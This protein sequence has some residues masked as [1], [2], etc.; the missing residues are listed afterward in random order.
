MKLVASNI[1]YLT[2]NDGDIILNITIPRKHYVSQRVLKNEFDTI[3]VHDLLNIN[4]T[5]NHKSR[6]LNQNNYFWKLVELITEEMTG[7][8]YESERMHVYGQ[9]LIEANVQRVG[10]R[11]YDSTL[12]ILER[13]FRAVI[14]IPQS[15]QKAENG[16]IT[17]GYW[18]YIGSSVFNTKEMATLIDI[19]LRWCDELNID[20][21]EVEYE[22]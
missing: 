8:K 16:E 4:I 13:Q 2:N 9:I 19:A 12:P 20:T 3:K 14:K 17:Y 21:R 7:T 18:C 11:A 22:K 10:L 15:M 6:T 5:K 1:N